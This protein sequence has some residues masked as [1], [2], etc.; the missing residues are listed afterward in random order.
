MS[1]VRG[2]ID[3]RDARHTAEKCGSY[4]A[5][6][7][8]LR[9]PRWMPLT[10]PWA[11]ALLLSSSPALAADAGCY[12]EIGGKVMLDGPC[13]ADLD[14][15]GGFTFDMTDAK[16]SEIKVT[17]FGDDGTGLLTVAVGQQSDYQNLEDLQ[18]HGRC[19]AN[20]RLRTCA[21]PERERRPL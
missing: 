5:I 18:R 8:E 21:W 11:L 4:A 3:G 7:T 2:A 1:R 10:R 19:W 15:D 20:D 12:L 9:K 6:M 16:G 13:H 17:V 14:D